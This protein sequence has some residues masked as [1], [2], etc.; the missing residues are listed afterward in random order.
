MTGTIQGGK[1][2]AETRG[3]KNTSD[4]GKKSGEHSSGSHSSNQSSQ[5]PNQSTKQS[6]NK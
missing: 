6:K 4:A 5:K 1:K 3:Q 2:A